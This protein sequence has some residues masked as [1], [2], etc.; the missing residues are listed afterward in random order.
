MALE[1]TVDRSGQA[2]ASGLALPSLRQPKSVTSAESTLKIHLP[3]TPTFD[4]RHIFATA[5]V[6]DTE[7]AKNRFRSPALKP[8]WAGT[9]LAAPF[10]HAMPLSK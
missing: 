2:Q 7:T 1:R 6:L 3:D 8:T 5:G 9:W 10:T 4:V